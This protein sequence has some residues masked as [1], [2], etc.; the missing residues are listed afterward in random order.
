MKKISLSL[1]IFTLVLFATGASAKTVYT[2]KKG[3]NLHDI[4]RKYRVTVRDI[5]STN[6]VNATYLK[7]GTKITIPGENKSSRTAKTT[8]RKKLRRT[9]KKSTRISWKQETG[10][11][12][13]RP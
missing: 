3:D 5:E 2:V 8:S 11:N 9:E 12:F 7:P 1:S 13:L 6:K 10:L 4:A